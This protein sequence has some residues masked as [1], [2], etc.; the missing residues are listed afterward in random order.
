MFAFLRPSCQLPRFQPLS[1]VI[2]HY[3]M[4]RMD[5]RCQH[6]L[7]CY[8]LE[9]SVSDICVSVSSIGS[10]CTVTTNVLLDW[11]ICFI[12]ALRVQ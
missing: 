6:A 8:C 11:I 1:K 4:Y 9:D 7:F 5:M 12:V 3:V 2:P 10:G